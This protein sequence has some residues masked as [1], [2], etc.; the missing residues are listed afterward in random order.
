MCAT[1]YNLHFCISDAYACNS[2]GAFAVCGCNWEFCCYG[3]R[4]RPVPGSCTGLA[5]KAERV[6]DSQL[7]RVAKSTAGVGSVIFG[8]YYERFRY[9]RF[10][11]YI[12]VSSKH[13]YILYINVC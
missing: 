9:F 7:R 3:F 12:I 4:D 2:V 11:H 13:L 1:A 6:N 8:I 10:T 5:N